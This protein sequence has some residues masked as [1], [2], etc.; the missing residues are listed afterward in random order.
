MQTAKTPKEAFNQEHRDCASCYGEIGKFRDTQ[1]QIVLLILW[2]RPAQQRSKRD[3]K[4]SIIAY[5]NSGYNV[6]PR[7]GTDLR[8]VAGVGAISATAADVRAPVGEDRPTAPTADVKVLPR[9][10][11][12]TFGSG[13]G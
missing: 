11:E 4:L 9:D 13:A 3:Q 8:D 10:A 2:K 6:L 12:A 5:E 7:G 1:R